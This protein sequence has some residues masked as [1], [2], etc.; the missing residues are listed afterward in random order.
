MEWKIR[1]HSREVTARL[2]FSEGIYHFWASDVGWYRIDPSSRTVTI[3]Q[4]GDAVRREVRLW[5]VPTM[6]C[7]LGLG[8]IPLHASAVEIAGRAVLFAAPGRFG[9]TTLALAFHR[10]GYRVLSEDMS[11]C[12]LTPG[13]VL[14]PGPA[15]VRLR[16]DVFD[17]KVPGGMRLISIKPDRVFLALDPDRSGTCEP[18]PIQA[19]IF[20]RESD[21]DIWLEPVETVR[22][23]PDLWSLSFRTGDSLGLAQSFSGLGQLAHATT[24]WNLYRPLRMEILDEVIS[25]VV[26]MCSRAS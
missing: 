22:A 19:I 17:G 9:K 25:R 2:Y 14:F 6:L 12:R 1:D 24:V 18:L 10:N 13:P 26:E 23:L 8:D 15:S 20:L 5:G 16:P 4:E 11:C 21:E 7:F 3:P